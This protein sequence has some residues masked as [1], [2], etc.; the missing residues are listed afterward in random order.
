MLG[1]RV[2]E[3]LVRDAEEAAVS[4]DLVDEVEDALGVSQSQCDDPTACQ[5]GGA[6]PIGWPLAIT[7]AVAGS[8]THLALPHARASSSPIFTPSNALLHSPRGK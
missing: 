5:N 4:I 1:V 2:G 6:A 3:G 7:S 8:T